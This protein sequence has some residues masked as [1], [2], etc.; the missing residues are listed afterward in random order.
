MSARTTGPGAGTGPASDLPH[1]W[2]PRWARKVGWF[3]AHVVWRTTVVG[4]ANVPPAGPVVI[5]A[6]HTGV[7][8]GPVLMGAVPRPTHFLV[9][10]EMFHGFV[11]WVLRYAGQIVV[12]RSG[13]RAGLQAA[14]GVLGRGGVVGVFPEG[15]RGRGDG[16][17]VHAGVAWL[18]VHGDAVVVPCAVLGTRRTGEKR[19]VIP[20]WGRRIYVEFGE[21]IVIRRTAGQS[22]RA[23]VGG[24][25]QEISA[26]LTA[27][28][29]QASLNSGMPLPDDAGV[30]PERIGS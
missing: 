6:N 22:D 19:G 13:G 18:A 1:P 2:G 17:N 9:K 27:L 12:D 28:I 26:A 4:A 16:A 8:D 7:A 20:G 24:A 25:L 15:T 21:P 29:G 14:K 3:L 11:G 5:A 23:A 10:K 30:E